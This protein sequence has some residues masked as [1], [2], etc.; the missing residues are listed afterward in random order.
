M[1]N[2]SIRST[3]IPHFKKRGRNACFMCLHSYTSVTLTRWSDLDSSYI[4]GM[5]FDQTLPSIASEPHS[6]S[7][8]EDHPLHTL[9]YEC[10]QYC[11]TWSNSHSTTMCPSYTLPDEESWT[12]SHEDP[13][14]SLLCSHHISHHSHQYT[15]ESKWNYEDDR[16]LETISHSIPFILY[17]KMDSRSQCLPIT[18]KTLNHNTYILILF[19]SVPT[20]RLMNDES[21]N[22]E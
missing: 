8:S 20:L 2:N 12:H 5:S 4:L 1:S 15:Y 6:L 22:V 7:H 19:H 14:D 17:H 11:S 21:T 18:S 13:H 16:S 3:R 9:L 10:P